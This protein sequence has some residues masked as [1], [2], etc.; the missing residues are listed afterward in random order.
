MINSTTGAFAQFKKVFRAQTDAIKSKGSITYCSYTDFEFLT[1][2]F[3]DKVSKFTETD[4]GLTYLAG[5]NKKNL[6]LPATWLHGS[7]RLINTPKINMILATD[8]ISDLNNIG[9][10][11]HI[12]TIDA[13]L[14]GT[15]GAAIQD[16]EA[17]RVSDQV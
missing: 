14:S 10:E 1:D 8:E 12:Y 15:I 9:T 16:P 3:Q 2:D 4:N 6:I 17:M 5:T 7:R 13:A 11:E